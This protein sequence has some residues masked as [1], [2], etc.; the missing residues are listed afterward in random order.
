MTVILYNYGIER[1]FLLRQNGVGEKRD[2]LLEY[3]DTDTDRYEENNRETD[4]YRLV[5]VTKKDFSLYELFRKYKNH[6]LV[7]DVEFQ[8]RDVWKIPQKIELIESILMGLPLPIFYFKQIEQ[9]VY[10]T[11]DGKQR[12]TSVFQYMSDEYPLKDLKIMKHLNGKKFSDLV[13][14]YGVFQSQ[15]EDYQIYAHVILPPTPDKILFNIFDRV[16][17][18]GTKLNKQEIRNALYNGPVLKMIDEI[19]MTPAFI[20]ATNIKP[21][22]DT[23]MKGSYLVTRFFAFLLLREEKLSHESNI[24]SYRGDM[25]DLLAKT[26]QQLNQSEKCYSKLREITLAC[27]EQA[28]RIFASGAFRKEGKPSNPLNMNI[29]ETA[30]YLMY[31]LN[32]CSKYIADDVRTSF[33]EICASDEYLKYIDRGGN[34]PEYVR[35]RFDMMDE[36]AKKFKKEDKYD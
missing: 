31:K 1:W 17:R 29:F 13:G 16:N 11:V 32:G 15:L 7:L 34:T 24:Y 8:R 25:D 12:L 26:L 27:L 36:L 35:G 33:H 2:E 18:G 20:S 9:A 6:K 14:D 3:D 30:M 5:R 21:A 28:K 23:R 10:I 22:N 4:Y 19:T